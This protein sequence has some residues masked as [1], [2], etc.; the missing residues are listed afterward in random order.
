MIGLVAEFLTI[1]AHAMIH[2]KGYFN[3]HNAGLP[4]SVRLTLLE[5]QDEHPDPARSN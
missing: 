2:S 1:L 4:D 3:E 5:P